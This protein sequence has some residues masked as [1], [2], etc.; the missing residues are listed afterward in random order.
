MPV[1]QGLGATGGADIEKINPCFDGKDLPPPPYSETDDSLPIKDDE[2]VISTDN[3]I[4]FTP[5]DQFVECRVRS[6]LNLNDGTTTETDM[7]LEEENYENFQ[8]EE[9][10]KHF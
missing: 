5:S 8:K 4:N 7:T 1:L 6:N 2:L 10:N 9:E 3:L